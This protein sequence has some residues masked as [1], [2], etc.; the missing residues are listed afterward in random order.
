MKRFFAFLLAMCLVMGIFAQNSKLSYQ[1]VVRNSANELVTNANVTV[2]LSIANSIS[3]DAVFSEK[4]TLTTNQNGL[5]SLMIGNGSNQ[6]GS[7]SNVTWA[8]AYITSD[9]TLPGGTHVINTVPVSAVP[10]ALYADTVNEQSLANYL[11][12]HHYATTS[13]VTAQVNADWNATEGAAEILNKPTLFSGDYNDL[14]NK[15]LGYGFYFITYNANTGTG[16][17]NAQV[18]PTGIAQTIMYNGF[19]KTGYDFAGWNEKADNSGTSHTEGESITLGESKTL[20]A[21]WTLQHYTISYNNNGGVGSMES[22]AY[23]FGTPQNLTANTFT[24]VGHIFNGWNTNADGSGIAYTDQYN[25]SATSDLMLYAQWVPETYTLT[26]MANNGTDEQATQTFT[27]GQSQ[28]LMSNPFTYTGYNFAD[29]NT[30]ADGTGDGYSDHKNIMLTAD[31]ILYARWTL[32]PTFTVTFN[33]NGG[34]GTMANQTFV[35]GEA[36]A[37]TLNSFTREGYDFMGWNTNASGMGTYYSDGQSITLSATTALYAKWQKNGSYE[38][39]TTKCWVSSIRSNE[40]GVCDS[41]SAVRDHQNNTYAVVQI[42]SQCWLKENMRAT[43]SPSTGTDILQLPAQNT[44]YTGKRAYYPEDNADTAA[45]YGVLYNWNAAVDTFNTA[46]GETSY[47]TNSG[48]AVNVTFIGNR[49]GICPEGWHIPS[50]NEWDALLT[51]AGVTSGGGAGKLVGGNAWKSYTPEADDD[52]SAPGNMAYPERNSTG[53]S[54]VPAGNYGGYGNFG[55]DAYFWS[56]IQAVNYATFFTL[57]YNYAYV[58]R[59]SGN[60]DYGYSVRCLRD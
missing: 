20:F 1:A 7:M 56:A 32:I 24:K 42:G 5:V 16:S 51:A 38:E 2:D 39:P 21:Q 35:Q 12:S 17:M 41:I 18:F 52:D 29:W 15:P 14:T 50:T 19:T 9:Y 6:T 22:Q 45:K 25:L 11:T 27:Y 40:T 34:I 26:F 33:A 37:L 53:F 47:G 54:A 49:R 55:N 48:N 23:V 57:Y 31:M 13:D 60:K 46:Y 59:T 36:Q 30:E 44:S 28:N 4:H 43:T 58:G 10:Y 8:T 3:G